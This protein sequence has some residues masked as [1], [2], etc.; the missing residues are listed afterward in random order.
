MK[1]MKLGKSC[2]V[3]L[4]HVTG[5]WTGG[6]SLKIPGKTGG[7]YKKYSKKTEEASFPKGS[8]IIKDRQLVR[9]RWREG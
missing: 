3:D 2:F 5:V 6:F 7:R 9:S 1:V 8:L 4:G